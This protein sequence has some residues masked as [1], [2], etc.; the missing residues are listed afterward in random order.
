MPRIGDRFLRWQ[1]FWAVALAVASFRLLWVHLGAGPLPFWDQWDAEGWH[2]YRAWTQGELGV[3]QLLAAHN[4][5]RILWPRLTA[6]ALFLANGQHWDSLVGTAFSAL[7]VAVIT[8]ALAQWTQPRLAPALRAPMLL[9]LLTLACLPIAWENLVSGFQI[10]FFQ[11]LLFSLLGLGLAVHMQGT[12]RQSSALVALL[13]AG[14]FTTA[15]GVLAPVVAVVV[16]LW[17]TG[18][19]EL[20]RRCLV[21]V[22]AL[23]AV[24]VAGILL[25][26]ATPHHDGL[27]AQS[28]AELVQALLQLLAWPFSTRLP[29][30]LLL[31]IAPLLW[32]PALLRDREV[33]PR[34]VVL[35]VAI[36]AWI[37]LQAIAMAYARGDDAAAATR[38]FDLLGVGCVVN[39]LLLLLWVRPHAG[40]GP[41]RLAAL[42][43]GLL[44]GATTLALATV[45]V[46]GIGSL[47]QHHAQ[48]EQQMRNVDAYLRTGDPGHLDNQPLLHIPYPAPHRLRM[49]LDDPAIVAMLGDSPNRRGGPAPGGAAAP[50]SAMA[51]AV[52]DR[53]PKL[54][55]L[56][57]ALALAGWVLRRLRTPVDL[58]PGHGRWALDPHHVAMDPGGR[59]GDMGAALG[60]TGTGATGCARPS[61]GLTAQPAESRP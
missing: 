48:V 61:S 25:L 4:E 47:G 45:A 41:A 6:L 40:A 33:P 19:G 5:H 3:S 31:W 39:V 54:L 36:A 52:L 26:P 38:Y 27:K 18:R 49:F 44:F 1:T 22:A 29:L 30:G 10:A 11:M 8:G 60:S 24:A 34:L 16:L 43:A 35:A 58:Q 59:T 20:P 14:L 50:L 17:R 32:L 28:A 51:G 55:T 57:L 7:F 37:G 15:A 13:L 56:L 53:A 21:T 12:W 46:D 23:A 2:L 9:L 42:A